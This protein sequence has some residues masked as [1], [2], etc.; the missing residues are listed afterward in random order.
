MT[1]NINDLDLFGKPNYHKSKKQ[2]EQEKRIERLNQQ[3]SEVK[4][5]DTSNVV[6]IASI[7]TI[8]KFKNSSITQVDIYKRN[9]SAPMNPNGKDNLLHQNGNSTYY[10]GYLSPATRR[11]IEQLL[12]VWLT[13]IE[14]S[15][16]IKLKGQKVNKNEVFPTFITLTLPSTQWHGDNTIKEKILKPFIKWLTSSDNEYFKIGKRKGEKKGFNVK[17]Y[18]WRA[19]AQKN[20]NIHFHLIVDRYIP[21]PR[22]REKWNQCVEYLGYVSRYRY[23]Q[24]YYHRNGFSPNEETISKDIEL[25]KSFYKSFKKSGKTEKNTHPVFEKYI[26]LL[27]KYNKNI[28]ESYCRSVA[29][30]KQKEIYEENVKC[31]WKNPNSTDIHAIQNLESITAYVVKYISKKP[32]E[33]PIPE[34]QMIKFNEKLQ[35]DMLYTYEDQID[36][37]TG[38]LNKVEVSCLEICEYKPKFDERRMRGRI[39]GCSDSLRG[40]IESDNDD[41]EVDEIGRTFK[42]NEIPDINNGG[43]TKIKISVPVMKFFS[44]KISEAVVVLKT[45]DGQSSVYVSPKEILSPETIEYISEMCEI[46]GNQEVERITALVGASFLKMR[47]KI[48]PLKPERMGFFQK[49]GRKKVIVK[50]SDILKKYAPSL[51][52]EYVAYY[53]HIY[54]T[55]YE[56]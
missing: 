56:T 32:T 2:I 33:L 30:L 13:S 26:E 16:N 39:W 14:V 35:K 18:M 50:H 10:N 9:G 12:S 52:K 37:I 31:G 40:F 47:G 48:I 46:V 7:E 25:F 15:Q 22:I 28:T 3:A 11:Q 41:I 21:W 38:E 4:P 24:E 17:V 23:M 55:L 5:H 36:E 29:I 53:Q 54:Q 20:K 43:T 6:E 44:K 45:K 51:Y 8:A 42:I 19:E 1:E 49:K 34:N 27:I